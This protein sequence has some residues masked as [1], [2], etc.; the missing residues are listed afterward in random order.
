MQ[1]AE[2]LRA[3]R[4][5]GLWKPSRA[6]RTGSKAGTADSEAKRT[7]PWEQLPS[8]SCPFL[9]K[10]TLTNL[11]LFWKHRRIIHSANTHQVPYV[12][13]D[14]EDPWRADGGSSRVREEL[15]GCHLAASGN[16]GEGGTPVGDVI[17]QQQVQPSPKQGQ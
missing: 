2:P 10:G 17:I 3:Q 4:S 15:W 6:G 11:Q 12:E 5:S 1:R 13:S 16:M 7:W 9:E 14:R 8:P